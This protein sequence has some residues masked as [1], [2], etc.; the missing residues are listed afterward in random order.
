MAACRVPEEEFPV[1]PKLPARR[2][3]PR[4]LAVMLAVSALAGCSALPGFM[5]FPPQVRGNRVDDEML[6]QLV[7]GTS[8]RADVTALIGSPTARATFDDNTW[9]YIGEVTKP[10]IGAT[11]AVLDQKVVVLT[12][13]AQG[14]LRGIDHKSQQDS[15]PVSVVARSTPAP[16]ND[17]S[18]LQQLLGN[19]GKFSPVATD[20]NSG[21]QGGRTNPGNF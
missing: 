14:V 2:L 8:T 19:V 12:F 15:V 4:L 3:A 6:S 18:F 5:T 10:V 17:T 1:L 21:R 13:D 16:G 20:S 7:P 9:L 11:N